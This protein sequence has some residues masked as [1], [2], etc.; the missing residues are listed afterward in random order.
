MRAADAI[1][2]TEVRDSCLDGSARLARERAHLTQREVAGVC[3]VSARA[4][5]LW[6]TGQRTPTGPPAL[7][8]G[9]LLRQLARRAAA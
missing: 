6:E 9:K 2:L 3:G 1:M 7:E 5:S 8:Y 4:I